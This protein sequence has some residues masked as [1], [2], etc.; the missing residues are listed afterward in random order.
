MAAASSGLSS[1]AVIGL[2][3]WNSAVVSSPGGRSEGGSDVMPQDAGNFTSRRAVFRAAAQG[4]QS[5]AAPD[6]SAA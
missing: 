2:P 4:L 1:R 6:V 3:R 5:R